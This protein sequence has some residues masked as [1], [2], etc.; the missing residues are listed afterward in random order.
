MLISLVFNVLGIIAFIT[1]VILYSHKKKIT[2]LMFQELDKTKKNLEQLNHLRDSMLEIT[3]AIVG[4]E[5][6]GDLYDI[7]LSKAIDAIPKAN[8]GSILMRDEN[9]L[10]HCSS[11]KGF[12]KEI[13]EDFALPLEETILWKYTKGNIY[14]TEVINDVT[15]VPE[16]KILPLTADPEIWSINSVISVPLFINKEIIGL[17]NIDSKYKNAFTLDD[18]KAMEYIRSNLEIALQKHFLFTKMLT[19]SRFDKLT[20]VY[21]RAYFLER[22][23]SIKDSADRYKLLFSLVVFDINDLKIV[24]DTLGHQAGD[25]LIQTFAKITDSSKRRSDLFARWGG[26]EF[27]ALFL[28]IDKKKI[29]EKILNITETLNN[30]PIKSEN[31]ETYC[32]FSYGTADY[33]EDGKDFDSL[34]KIADEKMYERKKQMKENRTP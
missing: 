32:K 19:L 5:N 26:D 33:P 7:I 18:L 23:Q 10:F 24:N 13:L 15:R 16:L 9:G 8:V 28:Q 4:T 25:Q 20:G 27:V 14:R 31:K 21:N 34:L 2:A 6:P 29:D 12:D 3:Q 1:L 22:F 30:T 17:L 11:Q